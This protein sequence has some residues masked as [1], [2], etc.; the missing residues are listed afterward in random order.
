MLGRGGVAGL[1][2]KPKGGLQKPQP[3]G[4]GRPA[5]LFGAGADED[6]DIDGDDSRARVQRELQRGSGSSS[7]GRA[8]IESM[9][10]EALERAR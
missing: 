5:S 3:R 7:L 4:A 2:L 9:Q 6:D 10:A 1:Q 8:A